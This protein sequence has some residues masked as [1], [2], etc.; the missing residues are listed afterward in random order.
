MGIG[1]KVVLAELVP[2]EG[3]GEQHLLQDEPKDEPL[4]QNTHPKED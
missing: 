1:H 2:L 4:V 3:V